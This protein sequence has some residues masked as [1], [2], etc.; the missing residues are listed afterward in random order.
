MWCFRT[1][2]PKA[3]PEV[4]IVTY[5]DSVDKKRR[6][7]D[8]VKVVQPAGDYAEAKTQLSSASDPRPE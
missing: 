7:R 5:P 6:Q 4:V 3:F 8:L 2:D 1:L